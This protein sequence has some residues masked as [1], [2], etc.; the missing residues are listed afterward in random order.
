[1]NKLA[2]IDIIAGVREDAGDVT[3][4]FFAV[5][6]GDTDIASASKSDIEKLLTPENS[7]GKVGPL[8]TNPSKWNDFQKN[9]VITGG[10]RAGNMGI[11]VKLTTTGKYCGN[12][13]YISLGYSD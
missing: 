13:D 12:I 9:T 5:D 11:F 1:M 10:G 6:T 2:V 4:E 3:A 8:V 7:L